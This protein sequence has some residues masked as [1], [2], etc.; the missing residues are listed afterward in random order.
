M[1]SF[2]NI[3]NRLPQENFDRQFF[4]FVFVRRIIEPKSVGIVLQNEF[5]KFD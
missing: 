4:R 2:K 5:E 1:V 3:T